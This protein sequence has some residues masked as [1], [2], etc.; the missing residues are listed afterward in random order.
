M[1]HS[2]ILWVENSGI[3]QG[4]HVPI[5]QTQNYELEAP[6]HYGIFRFPD[7]SLYIFHILWLNGLFFFCYF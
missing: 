6:V 5:G 7:V 2:V 1:G 3:E 4:G